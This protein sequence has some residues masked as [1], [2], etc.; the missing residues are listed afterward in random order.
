MSK[1]SWGTGLGKKVFPIPFQQKWEILCF[2]FYDLEKASHQAGWLT[3][4]SIM[5][6]VLEVENFL[7]FRC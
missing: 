3:N 4:Y 7:Y 1:I 5:G 6:S 2:L